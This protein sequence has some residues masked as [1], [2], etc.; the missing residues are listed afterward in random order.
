[1]AHRRAPR[2]THPDDGF[3]LIESLVAMMVL[4]VLFL[5]FASAMGA[6]FNSARIN[7]TTQAATAVAVEHLEH[8]RSL[9][10]DALAMS[11]IDP[12]APLIDAEQEVLL[13]ALARL[14]ND[15][16]LVASTDGDIPPVSA[17]SVDE[18]SYTVWAYVS[19]AGTGLRRVTV[20]VTWT[21]G[22]TPLTHRA[23]TLVSEVVTR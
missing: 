18:I 13:A 12:A 23:S 5:A 7:R 9:G 4:L 21:A 19:E 2:R 10:W 14:E 11:S 1:M 6:A 17:E 20:Y 8:A 22:A 15:E 16:P 3:T